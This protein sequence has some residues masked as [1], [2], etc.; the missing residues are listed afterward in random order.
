[1]DAMGTLHVQHEA[2]FQWGYPY[3][4]GSLYNWGPLI[5][6]VEEQKMKF[7]YLSTGKLKILI[8]SSDIYSKQIL[9]SSCSK[10]TNII[11]LN[12]ILLLRLRCSCNQ[13]TGVFKTQRTFQTHSKASVLNIKTTNL[14][15]LTNTRRFLTLSDVDDV[16]AKV[17]L[18]LKC[19]SF[20]AL[21]FTRFECPL[22]TSENIC[23]P[24]KLRH[25]S[26]TKFE[27]IFIANIMSRLWKWLAS[28]E[29]QMSFER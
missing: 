7:T 28:T 21:P 4:F 2:E 22:R 6:P 24:A 17:A 10:T 27:R 26:D 18:R 13:G 8:I 1:M 25:A 29:L 3:E 19:H 11:Y 23:F 5:A 12:R 20:V 16:L 9:L 15:H 14:A